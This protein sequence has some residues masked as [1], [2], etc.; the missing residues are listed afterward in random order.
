MAAIPEH[1]IVL[2]DFAGKFYLDLAISRRTVKKAQYLNVLLEEEI[3]LSKGKQQTEAQSS[4][5]NCTVN[6]LLVM[7]FPPQAT[8]APANS[9]K[10]SNGSNPFPFLAKFLIKPVHCSILKGAS[11]KQKVRNDHGM[12]FPL[13]KV[14]VIPLELESKDMK[15]KLKG[16][17]IFSSQEFS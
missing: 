9:D 3:K 5:A 6:S 7:T 10:Q 15:S 4:S 17:I 2:V 1:D 13:G 11:R 14:V 12:V 8:A 16:I